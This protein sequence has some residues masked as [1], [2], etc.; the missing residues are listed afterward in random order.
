TDLLSAVLKAYGGES[1]FNEIKS[2]EVKFNLS[3][4]LFDSKGYP[5]HRQP[6]AII[7]PH[8]PK[9]T[10]IGLGSRADEHWEYLPHKTWI[11][12]DD[13]EVTQYR[14]NPRAAFA[15]HAEN[16]PWDDMH[17]LYFTGYA[18]WN[19][20]TAPF[21]FRM[22]GVQTR[23]LQHHYE[24]GEK[25]RVLEVTYPD[26]FPT[27]NKI[28]QFY[29]DERFMLRRLD[30]APD[31]LLGSIASQYVFDHKEIGGLIF[32]TLR[33]V[34]PRDSSGV[35]GP[36]LVLLDLCDIVLRYGHEN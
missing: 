24:N 8:S 12:N 20:L 35:F 30:Y 4:L 31:V 7:N 2:I 1:R 18:M 32:P 29:Y 26:N 6:K 22:P 36:R 13:G 9:V 28:Q 27:H 34:V 16:S 3:G 21:S 25:W 10:F 15:Q 5:G 19:Y 23:E 11:E 14:D 17:L 33:R